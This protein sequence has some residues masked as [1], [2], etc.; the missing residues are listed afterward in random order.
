VLA[1]SDKNSWERMS[2]EHEKHLDHEL[3][4]GNC[5]LDVTSN[6]TSISDPLL[7]VDRVK[8]IE[9]TDTR[10][11]YNPMNRSCSGDCHREDHEN[12]RW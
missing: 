11:H 12:E 3:H 4:C 6:G 8:Q 10:I 7:H 5:H 9:F 2:G 1:E